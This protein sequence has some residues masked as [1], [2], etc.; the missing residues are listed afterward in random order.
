MLVLSVSVVI[1]SSYAWMVLSSNPVATGI[2]VAIG[3]GNTILIAPD[4]TKTVDGMVYHYPGAFSDTMNFGQQS[5]YDYLQEV[6]SLTPVSTYNG[7]DW[8]LPTYYSSD[9]PKVQEGLIPSGTIKDISEFIV[10]SELIYANLPA[11]E[12]D[13]SYGGHYVYLDFWVVS[14]GGDSKLRV[15]TDVDEIDGGSFVIDLLEPVDSGSGYTLQE[16]ESSA[17]ASVR[18][19]FLA[20]DLYLT[21]N[22]MLAYQN[23]SSYDERFT[24][25][26]GFYQEPDTG[27]AYLDENR[28]TIYEPNGDYHPANP[29]LDGS[30]VETKPLGLVNGQIGR[31]STSGNLTVQTKSIWASVE[32]SDATAIEQRFQTA[33]YGYSVENMAADVAADF[34]YNRYLQGQ[35]SP[36]VKKGGFVKQTTNLYTELAVSGSGA[37]SVDKLETQGAT[38]DVYIIELEKN[39]PQRIRMFIWVEGQDVDCSALSSS[40]FAVNIEFASGDE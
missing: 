35:I 12:T 40:Q 24:C 30:Y 34:F 14:P 5:A 10:D 39:V 32:G 31:L 27:T 22:S 19:G 3:G 25:L 9:D 11:S 37:V 28:F 16:P 23:S 21:D 13:G 38:D 15:S 1:A 33:L 8:I 17:A 6:G 7:V 20:N 26:K 18:V 4:V 2:Q 29:E 36:Y